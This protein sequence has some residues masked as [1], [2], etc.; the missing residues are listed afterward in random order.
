M[1]L[2]PPPPPPLLRRAFRP[3]AAGQ[4]RSLSI[5]VVRPAD[6]RTTRMGPYDSQ[7]RTV[8]SAAYCVFSGAGSGRRKQES[9]LGLHKTGFE[10]WGVVETETRRHGGPCPAAGGGGGGGGW[11]GW[12][13]GGGFWD[14]AKQ[15]VLTILGIIAA[16]FLI[17]NFNVLVG[18]AV[19]PLLLVLR[20]IRRAIT[21]ASYCVSR[22]MSAPTSKPKS[23]HVVNSEVAP[24]PVKGR[25]GVSARER[26]VSKWGSD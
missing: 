19:S 22:S 16:I 5:R 20:Q 13:S 18:A 6:F 2:A 15:T 24:V 1:S 10:R 8:G 12:F 3:S 14:A 25:V 21:F 4:S 9:V 7:G 17:A 26:V 23:T 11:F